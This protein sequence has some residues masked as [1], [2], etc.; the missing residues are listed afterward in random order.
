MSQ[1]IHNVPMG[2]SILPIQDMTN[3]GT[4]LFL[5][6][7]LHSV[8]PTFANPRVVSFKD[9]KNTRQLPGTYIKAKSE[10]P[11][12]NLSTAFYTP[13]PPTMSQYLPTFFTMLDQ[14]RQHVGGAFP[15]IYGGS[16]GGSKTKGEYE[17][18]RAQALQRLGIV[19]KMINVFWPAVMQ[20]AV[21]Q[22]RKNMAEDVKDVQRN[23]ND[24]VNVWIRKAEM[25]GKTGRVES[26]SSE[27]FP[28]AWSQIRGILIELLGLGIPQVNDAILHPENV[29]FMKK[30]IGLPQLH[31]QGEDDRR[32]QL[33]I[34][35]K[36]LESPPMMDGMPSIPPDPLVGDNDICI[37]I[38]QA[39]LISE[40]GLEAQETNP[41]GYMNIMLHLQMRMMKQ[42]EDMA[43]QAAMEAEAQNPNVPGPQG[44]KAAPQKGPSA[45][46]PAVTQ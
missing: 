33:T 14:R 25:G 41:E 39:W 34:I 46:A 8:P 35:N 40:Q 27:E 1:Y 29:D 15:S 10:I 38:T 44:S 24:F 21:R 28:V 13:S 16:G 43:V 32:Y 19:W 6:L 23:G 2:D 4:N 3:E 26:E 5:D 11:G 17:L 36:L 18:S 9:L 20:K 30:V 22:L 37:M 7:I 31:V 45:G 42:A 12:Q